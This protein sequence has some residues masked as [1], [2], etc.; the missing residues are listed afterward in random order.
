MFKLEAL[1]AKYGDCLIL[2]FGNEGAPRRVLIDG[3]PAWAWKNSLEPRLQALRPDDQADRSTPLDL[4]M[5]SHVDVDHIGGV[6]KL[7][8]AIKDARAD[9]EAPIA[10]IREL[11]HNSFADIVPERTATA[12]APAGIEL[13]DLNEV[14]P[15]E[16]MSSGARLVLAGIKDGRILRQLARGTETPVNENL[17]NGLVVAG[18]VR[19]LGDLELRVLGPGVDEVEALRDEWNTEVEALLQAEEARAAT[20]ERSLDRAIANL[21]SI[22]VL[23]SVGEQRML[24]TGDGRGDKVLEVLARNGLLDNDTIHVDLYKW[25]H[26]GSIRNLPEGF[27]RK[28][29]ADHHVVSADGRHG[30]PDLETFQQLFA[31]RPRDRPFTLHMTYG[32]DDLRSHYPKTE[33]AA[34]FEQARDDG[35]EFTVNEPEDGS[36]GLT[37]VL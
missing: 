23:A 9:H 18:T 21:S 33:L 30:N 15:S 19:S 27:F 3:G 7:F 24:L 1:K 8:E 14:I 26:H 34:L 28:V 10:D 12:A 17:D 4:L 25:P 29:T 36:L 20:A 6:I 13:A 32:I 35:H 22:V 37:V 2:H 11:W 31:E 5:V 16:R